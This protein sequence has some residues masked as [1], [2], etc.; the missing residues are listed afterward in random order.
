MLATSH[1]ALGRKFI[2]N[3]G[4][5]GTIYVGNLQSFGTEVPTNHH[6]FIGLRLG[7]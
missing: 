2:H 6:V 7:V 5:L 3:L 4:L 1:R